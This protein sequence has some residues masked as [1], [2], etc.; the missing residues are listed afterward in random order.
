MNF[1]ATENDTTSIARDVWKFVA[2]AVGLILCCFA[3]DMGLRWR[4]EHKKPSV[5][6]PDAV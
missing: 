5:S 6:S 3:V 1:I 2:S 4:G